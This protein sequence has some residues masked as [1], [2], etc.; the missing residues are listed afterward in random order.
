MVSRVERRY[1]AL[2]RAINVG[3]HSIVSK[4]RLKSC[5]ESLGV[6]DV[7]TYIQSGNILFTSIEDDT[8]LLSRR[9]TEG[10]A[11]LL[12]SGHDVFVLT[13][14]ELARVL[15]G[16][17]FADEAAHPEFRGH[18]MFLS[19]TPRDDRVKALRDLARGEYRFVVGRKILYYGYFLRADQ[20]R[21]T[22]DIE[23]ILG[24][25]G[26]SRTV[27]VVKALA[28]LLSEKTC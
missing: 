7:S 1:V 12:G 24:V 6:S 9:V 25:V 2:V 22:I 28:D 20:R 16:Y 18:V 13:H 26:T 21:R 23:G 27:K 19:T 15:D 4:D 17:P 5:V 3:G 10:L 11:S 14:D 8:G